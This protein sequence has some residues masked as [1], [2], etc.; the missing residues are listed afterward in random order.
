VDK[1][2]SSVVLC[3]VLL[4]LISVF[5][6]NLGGA[7]DAAIKGFYGIPWGANLAERNELKLVEET[8]HVESYELKDGSPLLG[9]AKL[10]MLRFVATDGQFARVAIR[11]SGEKNHAH[12]LT[13]LQS[14]FG[15]IERSLGSMMRGLNQQFTWRSEETEVNLTYQSFQER[16]SVFIESRTLAP[17]FNDVLPE[18][19]Y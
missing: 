14:I 3:T 1:R 2:R 8:E 11:Y 18:S 7:E 6:L 13:Y 10:S 15:P 19:A 16:G 5:D 4:L 9:E 12:I 17:R